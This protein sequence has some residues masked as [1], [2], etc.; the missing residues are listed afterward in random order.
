V[1]VPLGSD[2][3]Y[4]A[5]AC[6]TDGLGLMLKDEEASAERIREAVR[7]VLDEPSFAENAR[8]FAADMAQRPGFPAAVRRI[9]ALAAA[10]SRGK[11]KVTARK[12]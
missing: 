2:Q 9:E 12:A 3:E 10:R 11:R 8:A 4:N 6:A 1:C 5:R 7:R